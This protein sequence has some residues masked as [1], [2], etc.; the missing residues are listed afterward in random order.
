MGGAEA[1]GRY[2][3]RRAAKQMTRRN[4][5]SMYKLRAIAALAATAI[6]PT[7]AQTNGAQWLTGMTIPRGG[8]WVQ[9][10]SGGHYW[11]PDGVNGLQRIRTGGGGTDAADGTV[12][13]GGQIAKLEVGTPGTAGF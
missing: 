6:L 9:D 7:A 2:A 8:V 4:Y 5:G 3:S 10:S 12:K 13:S 1:M 11:T